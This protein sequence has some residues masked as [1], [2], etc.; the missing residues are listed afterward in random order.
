MNVRKNIYD[1]RTEQMGKKG[2]CLLTQLELSHKEGQWTPSARRYLGQYRRR[3]LHVKVYSQHPL[4]P[5]GS[6]AVSHP[7][8]L[9]F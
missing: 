5:P 8:N 9:T 1:A 7:L 4:D 2:H 3:V 6:E